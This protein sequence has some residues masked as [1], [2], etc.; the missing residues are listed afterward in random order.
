VGVAA[1]TTFIGPCPRPPA[2]PPPAPQAANSPPAP[3]P[4]PP[5]PVGA[6]LIAAIASPSGLVHTTGDAPATVELDSGGTTAALLR[7]IN[8]YTWTVLSR[9]NNATIAA[10]TGPKASVTLPPGA[11]TA[12]LV[13]RDSLGF[14][15]TRQRPFVVGD[16][17]ATA[18]VISS[19]ADLE[20]ANAAAS[21]DGS[22][23]A[24]VELSAEGSA[25][26]P[27]TFLEAVAWQVQQLPGLEVLESP[28][29]M[30]AHITLPVVSC[31]YCWA[32]EG[33]TSCMLSFPGKEATETHPLPSAH[34]QGKYIANVRVTDSAGSSATASK[35]FRVG[36]P[37][38]TA[39]TA[40]DA[41]PTTA[42][43]TEPAPEVD[44]SGSAAGP[45]KMTLDAGGSA[46]AAGEALKSYVWGVVSL[47]DRTPV[48]S[49]RGEVAE[50]AL[51]PGRYQVGVVML[52]GG[53]GG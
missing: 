40:P 29:G 5:A 37:S 50:V 43:I 32:V 30:S 44:G 10:F 22:A 3:A 53:L 31:C 1:G 35:E 17:V 33:G 26:G 11:Y 21:P 27:G 51:M 9:P 41:A 25:A 45:V 6:R 38:I 16:T 20:A 24:R 7:P 42:V 12:K 34:T 13:V 19:P 28:S 39:P 18:A 4:A 15:S 36:V 48:T 23:L 2:P 52:W 47:P 14:E 8:K 46:A 49:A